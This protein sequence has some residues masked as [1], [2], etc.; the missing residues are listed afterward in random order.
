MIENEID[1]DMSATLAEINSRGSGPESLEAPPSSP[2]SPPGSEGTT[3]TP[4][5]EPWESPPKSWKKD[6]HAYW[7]QLDPKVRQ[8]VHQREKE[9]LDG[10]MQ[11]KSQADKWNDAVKQFQPWFDHYKID[12]VEAFNRLATSHIILKYGSPE[13]KARW[14][15]QLVQDYGLHDILR[16][17]PPQ[18]GQQPSQDIIALRNEL[19]NIQKSL[20]ERQLQENLAVVN[21]FFSDPKNEF[22]EELQNDIAALLEKGAASTLQ[23]AYEKAMWLNPEVRA[24]VMQREIEKVT[25]PKR[26]ATTNL[27]SS[28][29]SPAPTEGEDESMEDTMKAVL[30]RINTR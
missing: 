18:Q 1:T 7:S 10:I 9:A 17:A 11:Y 20:Y 19:Q 27:K 5:P 23:E 30:S 13:D 15:W 14:A 25:Q 16:G 2:S 6:Y 21:A 26:V 3:A 4:A 28:S 22:A 8:Y 12:P 24:K 29:V